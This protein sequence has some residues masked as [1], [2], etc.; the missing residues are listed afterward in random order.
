VDADNDHAH[1]I[2]AA[3]LSMRGR[4][5]EAVEHLRRSIALNPE[6]RSQAKQDPDLENIRGHEG[7]RSAIDTPAASNRRK[8]IPARRR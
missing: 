7:F 2:M 4:R 6:N 1:Y 5:D 3:A 8:A